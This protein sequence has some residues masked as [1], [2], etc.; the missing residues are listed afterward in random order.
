MKMDLMD[1]LLF[2]DRKQLGKILSGHATSFDVHSK[3]KMIEVLYPSLINGNQMSERYLLLPDEAKK[4]ILTLC[5][6]GKLFISKEE[7]FGLVPKLQKDAFNKIIE[8][9]LNAGILFLY[10]DNHILIPT[11]IKQGFIRLFMS[12]LDNY[13]FVLPS[14][15]EMDNEIDVINDI[16]S[17][18]DVIIQTPLPLT[19]NGL[20]HKRDFEAIMKLFI[21]KEVLPNEQWRF[22]YGRRFAKYPDRF[23]LIYDYCFYKGWIIEKDGFLTT[24]ERVGELEELKLTNFIQGLTHFWLK[25]YKRPIPSIH[26]L[27]ELL[28]EVVEDG[29]GIEEEGMISELTPFVDDYYY[30]TKKDIIK[31]RFL[32]MLEHINVIKSVDI[33]GIY[34]YTKGPAMVFL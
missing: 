21:K 29:F 5:Y 26:L 31:K 10:A 8:D 18:V 28:M 14:I 11:Q 13:R 7:L 19:K 32:N 1:V 27:F 25:L 4:I 3:R 2:Q 33:G 24:G 15:I 22:G 30:D 9:L 20:L 23:S 34:Y 6:N 16:F 17:F 12:N